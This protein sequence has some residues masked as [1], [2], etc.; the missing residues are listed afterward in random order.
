MDKERARFILGS[1][2][3]NGAD[4]NDADFAE[5]LK[6]AHE[7]RELGEWLACE[8]AFDA[9]FS[10]SLTGIP[11]P[12]TLREE[13]IATLAMDRG[14]FPQA[15]NAADAAMI[16]AF[17]RIQP[18]DGFREKLIAAME[19]SAPAAAPKNVVSFWKKVTFPTAAAA[20]IALAFFLT[21]PH[22]PQPAAPAAEHHRISSNIVEASFV[23]TFQSPNFT[24]EKTHEHYGNLC[25]YLCNQGLPHLQTLPKGMK[26]MKGLG[27]RELVIDGKRGSLICF[28]SETGL[29]HLIV[30]N[31]DDLE[32]DGPY[33]Q[34]IIVQNGEWSYARWQDEKCGYM[35]VSKNPPEK[36][37]EYF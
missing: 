24:F 3:P 13:I 28:N 34:P 19:L 36:L 10:A 21:R 29:V 33:G 23:K 20:G 26:G 22:P 2:R 37:A 12:E 14:D 27:C 25:N 8:R 30:F 5:A 32:E 15:Q 31:R 4:V 1:F 11:L 16:G 35:L 9:D 6:I 18:P 7:D 17:S